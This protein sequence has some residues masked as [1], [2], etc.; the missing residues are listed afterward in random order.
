MSKKKLPVTGLVNELHGASA[1]FRTAAAPIQPK[2]KEPQTREST[3][4][5]NNQNEMSAQKFTQK[6]TQPVT[7]ISSILSKPPSTEAI[8][9]LSFELRK[10]AKVRVNADIPQEWKDKL[11][12]LTHKLR[13]GKYEFMLYLIAL[14]IG[15]VRAKDQN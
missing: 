12:D 3:L 13:V 9:Q 15:K 1:F 10:T 7:Q 5:R 6:D 8:E 14:A 2:K 4:K 11:D